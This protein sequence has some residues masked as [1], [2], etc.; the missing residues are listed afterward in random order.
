MRLENGGHTASGYAQGLRSHPPREELAREEPAPL[1][2][3]ANF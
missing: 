2:V 3:L 1:V